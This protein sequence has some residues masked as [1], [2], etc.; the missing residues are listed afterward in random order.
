MAAFQNSIE[1]DNNVTK[2]QQ[3]GIYAPKLAS[4]NTHI[5]AV[6]PA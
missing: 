1:V 2:M 4:N 5:F 6:E 3:L